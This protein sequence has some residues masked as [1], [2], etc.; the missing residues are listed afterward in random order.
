[1]NAMVWWCDRLVRLAAPLVPGDIRREWVREWRAELAFACSR[2]EKLGTRMPLRCLWRA[3]GAFFHAAWLRWDRWRIEMLLQDFKYAIRALRRKP[4]FTFVTALTL[5]IGIGGTTAIFGAV[6][7]VLL[8]PLPYPAPDQLVQLYKTTLKDPDRVGGAV[9]PPDFVDWR[10]D[11]RSFTEVAAFDT[12]SLA[13]TG[14]GAAEVVRFGEVTGAFFKVL[15][16]D[17][18]L[19]RA[20]TPDDD[21]MGGRDVVV[22]GH[23]IWTRRFGA[24]RN[25]IGRQVTIDSVRREVVGVMP[26][27]VE[28]PLRSDAWIPLRFSARDLETQRGAHYV[29]VLARTKPEVSIDTAREDMRALGARLAQEF[30]RTNRDTSVSVHPLR[31]SL[32]GT[33]RQSMFVLLGAVGLVLVIVCVNVASLVLVRGVGRGRELAVRVAVGAG[34]FSLFRGLLIESLVLG[35]IGGVAGLVLAYWATSAIAAL[36]PSIGVPLLN[37]TRLDV[38]VVSFAFAIALL[39]AVVFGTMPAWQA[40]SIGD[41]VTRIREEGGSTTGDP[42]RQRT[43]SLLIVAETTL[44]VIL[45]VG[46]G[47]LTRSFSRLL[48]VDLGFKADAVQT[49]SLG[50]PDSRYKQPIQRQ[51]LIENFLNRTR[52]RT[53]VESAA[54][55]FGLPLS[56]FRFGISTSTRDG[57]TLSDDE[58]DALTL[59]VRIVTPEYFRTM[60]IAVTRGRGFTDADQMGSQPVAMLSETAAA[61]VFPGVDALG[62]H[63]SIGTRFGMGGER[64]G[65]TVVG[66]V[67]DVLDYGPASR[68]APTLYLAYGQ[69]PVPSI[70]IV[71][72]SRGEPAALVEPMRATL[73]ELDPD[74]PMFA[75]RSM[76][77]VQDISVAQP[78]L[79]LVL[80]GCFAVTALLLAAIG[81]YGVLAYAVG[82]RTREIGI[83]LALGA[84][85]TEVLAMVMSQAG[86]LVATGVVLGLIG[87]VLASRLLRAQLFEVAPTDTITYVG[88]AVA[89]IVVAMFASW[90]PARRAARI[91]PMTALRQD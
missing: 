4:G 26:P 48:S 75:V 9:S 52:Q 76:Q 68:P 66:I 36:D 49:F 12:A 51:E 84:R 37:N 59:Q 77:Q 74:L 71:A 73:R 86:K 90:I 57:I 40:T 80:I 34:R 30:P 61:R 82:Q 69:W 67:D 87:A 44:A 58:Q 24:D 91:D 72:K 39:S 16:V 33:I 70:S 2:A 10:R 13:L 42:K 35:V 28:F 46:A 41:V 31:D 32:V 17:A 88:V 22:L 60:Q 47:L 3:C 14:E 8:R 5:A 45:L 23:G 21:P 56:N 50:L 85:R 89:L 11:N 53:D 18:M 55:V 63:L 54:A 83:R 64:A 20:I 62:H 19:G 81:L 78:R 7:A 27:G 38:V 1:M 25:I 79:Y 6:N 65:G 43:R 29:S 15:A